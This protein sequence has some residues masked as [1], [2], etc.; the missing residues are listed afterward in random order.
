[1]TDNGYTPSAAE[2]KQLRETTQAGMMDCR[3]ALQ[4]ASGDMDSAVKLLRERGV[5]S[6]AKRSGRGTGEGLMEAYVHSNG[7]IGV[8]VEIGCET[9]FVARNEQFRQF[10]RKVATQI[11]AN[12]DTQVLSAD[13]L[14]EEFKASEIEVFRNKAAADGRPEAMLDKIA[15]GMWQKSLTSF[16]LLSQPSIRD[17]DEGRTIEQLRAELSGTMG[18]NIQI[19]RFARFE[20]GEE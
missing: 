17:E 15:E 1:V 7:R 20:V 12:A 5:A 10:A 6:A 18:E 14:S 19:K 4:D 9:D 13:A 11:A 8:L 3:Q 2:V 16:V